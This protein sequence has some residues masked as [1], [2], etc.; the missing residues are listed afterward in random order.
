MINFKTV[1]DGEIFSA[2]YEVNKSKFMA[3]VVHVESEDSA[4]EFVLM[5]RK[6][7]FDARLA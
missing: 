1:A 6:K 3:H 5:I 7:Y 4:R 2:T